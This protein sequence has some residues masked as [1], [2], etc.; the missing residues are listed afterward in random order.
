MRKGD[1]PEAWAGSLNNVRLAKEILGVLGS[2][3]AKTK[4]VIGFMLAGVSATCIAAPSPG[5]KFPN[6]FVTHD[7]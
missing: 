4:H 5:V 7:D 6:K 2:F 3:P 1:T